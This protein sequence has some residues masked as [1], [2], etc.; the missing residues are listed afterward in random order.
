MLVCYRAE[1]TGLCAA[2]HNCQLVA[3]EATQ[4]PLQKHRCCRRS[5]VSVLASGS[6]ELK[7]TVLFIL[8]K[9]VEREEL[10]ELL[11]KALVTQ[12]V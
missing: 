1:L 11:L 6:V 10:Q 7:M 12:K 3:G 4:I 2:A 5:R 8:N 9:Y